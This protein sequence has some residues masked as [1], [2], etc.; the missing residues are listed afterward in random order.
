MNPNVPKLSTFYLIREIHCKFIFCRD[1]KPQLVRHAV[2]FWISKRGLIGTDTADTAG[3][4]GVWD[5][6]PDIPI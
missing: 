2:E 1:G 3:T 4:P 5:C 6:N